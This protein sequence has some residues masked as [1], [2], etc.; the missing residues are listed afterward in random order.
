M[1]KSISTYILTG[2]LGSGKTTLLKRMVE[3]AKDDGLTPAILLNELGSENVEKQLFKDEELIE[4]LDGCICCTIQDDMRLEI[5]QLVTSREDID[6]LFIEGTGIANPVEIVE[7]LAHPNVINYVNV[8]QVLGAVDASRYL[9]FQSI[10]QS[11]KEIR[12]MLKDQIRTSSL[13]ILNKIDLIDEKEKEKVKKRI[14]KL[15]QEQVNIIE[16]TYG[17]VSLERLFEKRY[18]VMK[19]SSHDVNDLNHHHDHHDHPFQAVNITDI[20]PLNKVMLENWLK[21]QSVLLRAKGYL[22]VENDPTLYSCQY[23]SGRMQLTAVDQTFE[24]CLILIGAGL[25]DEFVDQFKKT[26]HV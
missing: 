20:P 11:S 18:T 21:K 22:Y 9:E 24:P 13:I 12:E 7:A 17:Q 4:M 26:F 3:K 8:H 5:E 2:F 10:F 19:S 25:N 14:Q 15:K 1:N 6:V 23:S 16:A